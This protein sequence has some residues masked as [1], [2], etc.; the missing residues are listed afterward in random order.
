MRGDKSGRK[1]RNEQYEQYE[2][3]KLVKFN[4]EICK[5]L[6]LILTPS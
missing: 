4:K 2:Q 1:E 3:D 6:G 5:A